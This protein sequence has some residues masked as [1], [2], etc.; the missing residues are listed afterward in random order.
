MVIY[1]L[2]KNE[3]KLDVEEVNLNSSLIFNIIFIIILSKFLLHTDLYR[4][5]YFSSFI[6]II[7]L[8]VLVILDVIQ[9]F[10][11]DDNKLF[12]IIY[13]LLRIVRVLFYSLEDV[14]GKVILLYQYFTT[15]SLLLNKAIIEIIS[16]IIFSF[17]FIFIKLLMNQILKGLCSI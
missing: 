4:H 15:Y 3:Y 5:H 16:S 9:I 14:I 2:V 12:S 8:L 6:M 11:Q 7:C 10:Q 1:Y 17:P 13:M